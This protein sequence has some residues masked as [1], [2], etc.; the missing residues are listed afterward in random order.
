MQLAHQAET[1]AHA[2]RRMGVGTLGFDAGEFGAPLLVGARCP[3]QTWPLSDPRLPSAAEFDALVQA[4]RPT[5]IL[6]GTGS[7]QR[8]PPPALLMP[9]LR[10][11]IGVEVMDSRAAARTYNVLLGEGREVLLALLAD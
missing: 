7:R 11:G 3:P 4:Q 9:A 6:L 8:F 2:V 10:N 1:H 5:V